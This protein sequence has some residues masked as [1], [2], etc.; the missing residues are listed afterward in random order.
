MPYL[1]PPS[2]APGDAP[3][4]SEW[5]TFVR[6]NV[7]FLARPPAVKVRRTTAQSIATGGSG[8]T[9]TFDEERFDTDTMW[10]PGAPAR[11]SVT[12]AGIYAIS[13]GA[14]F[15]TNATGTRQVAVFL[16]GTTI[17]GGNSVPAVS[18]GGT[19]VGAHVLYALTV[20]DYLELS[21]FQSSGGALDVSVTT[22][23]PYLEAILVG[24]P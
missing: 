14:V 21:V 3:T 7:A 22:M 9:I 2:L 12:T 18:G 4:A 20:G 6:G 11:L 24:F 5:N 8:A 1:E 15:A 13:A 23:R 17:I 19:V 16:N 10:D